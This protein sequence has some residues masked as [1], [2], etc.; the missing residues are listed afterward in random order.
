MKPDL[1]ESPHGD[2]V[3]SK[4]LFESAVD[5]LDRESAPEDHEVLGALQSGG[6]L[7]R[8]VAHYN[9]LDTVLA[10]DLLL[11]YAVGDVQ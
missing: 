1:R 10:M 6:L 3:G 4:V 11:M 7:V 8:A 2:V 9:R 5:A